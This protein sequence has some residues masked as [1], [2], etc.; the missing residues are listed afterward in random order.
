LHNSLFLNMNLLIIELKWSILTTS[1]SLT[2]KVTKSLDWRHSQKNYEEIHAIKENMR[3]NSN[4]RSV[5]HIYSCLTVKMWH[6]NTYQI[7]I[8]P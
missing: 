1:F 6:Q 7:Y 8:F 4:Q 2:N 3:A 5:A